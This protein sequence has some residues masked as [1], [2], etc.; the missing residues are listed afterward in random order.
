[1]NIDEC[2]SNPCRNGAACVD[3]ENGYHC[4]CAVGFLGVHCEVD[5]AVCKSGIRGLCLNGGE[6]IDGV[7][8][9]YTCEC[10]AGWGGRYCE[11]DVDECES[12]PCQNGAICI[13]KLAGYA[14]A[15][16]LGFTGA[17]CAEELIRCDGMEC[18]NG[19]L[20]LVESGGPRCYC[21]PDYHGELCEQRYDECQLPKDR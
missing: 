16:A 18:R 4:D 20:C 17:N 1:M 13:D 21:V 3:L 11:L 19:G 15:C 9:E 2:Q 7:G 12:S 6:C 8:M 5:V 14:C 10:T